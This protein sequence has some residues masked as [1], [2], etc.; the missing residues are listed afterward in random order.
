LAAEMLQDAEMLFESSRLKS[1]A[2]RA[3]YSMFHAAQAA[4][5]AVGAE[6][7]RSHRGL[8]S[9]FGKRLV[10]RGLIETNYAKDL[11]QA[12]DVRQIS[13]YEAYAPLSREGVAELINKAHGF[14]DRVKALIGESA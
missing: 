6:A 12:G 13:T 9:E 4:L 11:S 10:K 2:D 5:L 7:T 14:L 1:A 3:Y 8:R